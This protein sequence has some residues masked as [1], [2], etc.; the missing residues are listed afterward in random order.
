MTRKSHYLPGV[1]L[2]ELWQMMRILENTLF[3]FS[4]QV[5]ISASLGVSAMLLSSIKQRA[6][7]IQLLR[8]T[9]APPLF[10]F[11]LIEL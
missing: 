7:E 4:I 6:K 3:L 11:F 1:A 8:V 10:L 2:S 5:F 9:G